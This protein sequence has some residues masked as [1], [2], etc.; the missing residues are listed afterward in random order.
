[1]RPIRHADLPDLKAINCILK[2]LDFSHVTD[3]YVGWLNDEKIN[4]YLESRF[5]IHTHESVK[6]F[7][8]SQIDCGCVLFYG[9]W[10]LDN[11]HIGNIKLGPFDRNHFTADVGFLIG[12]RNYWGRGIA[13]SAVQMIN[14]YG[15][16]LGLQKITAGAYEANIS[17]IKV[18]KKCGFKQEGFRTRQVVCDGRRMGTLLFGLLP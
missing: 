5:C 2:P 13:S 4:L 9:I 18:L 16:S 3:E 7:L 10:S 17:S 14:R 15:F 12:N 6:Q 8:K 11:I 1:M